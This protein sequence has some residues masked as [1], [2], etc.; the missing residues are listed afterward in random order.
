MI[1]DSDQGLPNHVMRYSIVVIGTSFGGLRALTTLVR[2]LP[3]DFPLPI[4]VVQH[5]SK[6]SDETLQSLLASLGTLPVHEAEDKDEIH[7]GRVYLAPADYHLLVEP[8]QFV[9]STEA[10][11]FY[12]RP[13]I[14]ALFESAS[15]AYGEGVVGVV[16]TGANS[17]GTAGLRRIKERGGYAIV[18]D[19]NT[20]EGS[21]MPRSALT[22][23][24]PD[25][26]LPIDQIPV[27]LVQLAYRP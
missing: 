18:E 15:D 25:R 24:R 11:V 5:R 1:N 22:A 7:A 4:A 13:S 12:S 6:D 23:V 14:D 27:A 17:D 3:R 21:A 19:P 16:L 9:L 10:P 8:G 20:A 26:V 2:G